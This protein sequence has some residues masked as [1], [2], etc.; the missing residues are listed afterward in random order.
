MELLQG[1]TLRDRLAVIRGFR[2]NWPS[3]TQDRWRTG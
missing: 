1:E 2:E 3:T